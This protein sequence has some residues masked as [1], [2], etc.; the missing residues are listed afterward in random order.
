MKKVTR[1]EFAKTCLDYDLKSGFMIEIDGV[2][3]M[4][5]FTG[6][7][8]GGNLKMTGKLQDDDLLFS[9]IGITTEEGFLEYYAEDH[10]DIYVD[11][12]GKDFIAKSFN[13]MKECVQ[14]NEFD[15]IGAS[16]HYLPR[17]KF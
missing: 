15:E 5:E 17:D 4:Q 3:G 16:S 13:Y 11:D 14:N 10:F 6:T 8:P 1:K 12:F 9:S 2:I 7:I